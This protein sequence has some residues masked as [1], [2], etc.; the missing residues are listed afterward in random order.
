MFRLVVVLGL[1][2]FCAAKTPTDHCCSAEDRNIVQEQWKALWKDTESSKIKIGFG[3]KIILKLVE[4]KPEA[5]AL[6]KGVNIDNPDSGLFAAHSMRILNAVDMVINL[7]K[8]PEAL[9]AALD[10]LADQHAKVTD[11]KKEYFQTFGEILAAALPRVLDD[12]NSLSWKSCF[13]YIIGNI[14]S[15]LQA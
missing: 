10:H 11:I 13:R 8:D 15:K 4:L 6:F 3:R 12:Y 9:D 1:V 5:K 7:L 14:A 2:A